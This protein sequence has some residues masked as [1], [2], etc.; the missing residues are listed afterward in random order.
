MSRICL[1]DPPSRRNSSLRKIKY[2][3]GRDPR[4]ISAEID[5][6]P[7]L[8]R[9]S[10]QGIACRKV[11]FGLELALA[12]DQIEH[13]SRVPRDL[14]VQHFVRRHIVA[15]FRKCKARRW[16]V[17]CPQEQ[18]NVDI[19]GQSGFA[20]DAGGDRPGDAVGKREALQ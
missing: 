18:D 15:I 9:P 8:Q 3:G 4:T 5:A 1:S 17:C 12:V 20:I 11:D 7:V 2:S 19:R 16:D 14:F 13:A 10:V 6:P